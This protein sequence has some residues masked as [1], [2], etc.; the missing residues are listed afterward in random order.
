MRNAAERSRL[1][2]CVSCSFSLHVK[3]C[4]I[5]TSRSQTC[6][7]SAYRATGISGQTGSPIYVNWLAR[8]ILN[9]FDKT[10][11]H[12]FNRG[13]RVGANLRVRPQRA[14]T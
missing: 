2:R 8:L 14:D 5:L 13:F 1:Q 4:E 9:T 6:N 12:Q 7:R 11:V 10:N 3:L